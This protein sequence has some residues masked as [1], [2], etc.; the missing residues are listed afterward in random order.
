MWIRL[1]GV[2]LLTGLLLACGDGSP[3]PLSTEERLATDSQPVHAD[4]LATLRS[5]PPD[6]RVTIG[7]IVR[8]RPGMEDTYAAFETRTAALREQSGG[9][10]LVS[11]SIQGVLVGEDPFDL[12]R[13]VEYPTASAYL[14]GIE[15]DAYLE[16]A[17][18]ERA[19]VEK[20]TL[21][22]GVAITFPRAT[23]EFANPEFAGL[24]RAEAERL[25]DDRG[26]PDGEG[27]REVIV[28]MIV[29][30]RLDE[31][32]MVNLLDYRDLAVYPNG[33]FPGS[34][35][36]EAD[37][38]YNAVSRPAIESRNGG[39][40]YVVRVDG[41]LVGDHPDW[42]LMATVRY[43]SVD[44]LLDMTLDPVFQAALVHK[45]AAL[46]ATEVF[47]TRGRVE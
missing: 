25:V 12:V 21:L 18:L 3:P 10:L 1:A 44:A 34:T 29:E 20:K 22:Y 23:G 31:F 35:G 6:Q 14:A 2:S 5:A 24:T 11:T 41:V 17:R 26:D 16:A 7:E 33:E 9:R 30:D 46:E 42:E 8:L 19:A 37:A 43:A 38:R 40:R 47:Y 28:D 39:V 36:R 27:N 45:F 32:F 4:A 15:S 13:V